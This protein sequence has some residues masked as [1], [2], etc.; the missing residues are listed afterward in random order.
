MRLYLLMPLANTAAKYIVLAKQDEWP[1]LVVTPASLR[2]AWADELARWLPH[3][4]PGSVHVIEGRLDRLGSTDK[5]QVRHQGTLS[6][7]RR[8]V[9]MHRQIR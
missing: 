9:G 6:C 2:L 8:I 1:A 5:P 3:L 4:R 7:H